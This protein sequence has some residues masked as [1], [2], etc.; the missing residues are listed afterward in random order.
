MIG[1][2]APKPGAFRRLYFLRAGEKHAPTVGTIREGVF[3]EMSE[4]VPGG[5]YYSIH[6]I[7]VRIN[8]SGDD[9]HEQRGRTVSFIVN[10]FVRNE[11]KFPNDPDRYWYIWGFN[12]E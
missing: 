1:D 2:T 10:W 12:A 4:H 3:P 5:A 9:W 11:R 7:A 6:D 8:P